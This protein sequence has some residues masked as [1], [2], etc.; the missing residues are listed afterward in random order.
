[1][2]KEK[3]SFEIITNS[4]TNNNFCCN[5]SNINNKHICSFICR[6]MKEKNNYFVQEIE[7]LNKY[8]NRNKKNNLFKSNVKLKFHM[9]DTDTLDK[10]YLDIILKYLEE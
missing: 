1:M 6:W 2:N 4:K 5:K 10:E 8:L 7:S 3:N 9:N